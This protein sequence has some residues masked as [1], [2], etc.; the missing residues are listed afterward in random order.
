MRALSVSTA[1]F[2]A[3]WA[4]R[5]EGE[6]T[7]NQILERLL[8]INSATLLSESEP[9]EQPNGADR[10]GIYMDTFDIHFPEGFVIFRIYKGVRYEAVVKNGRWHLKNNSR[11]YPSLHKLSWAVVSGREN[12]W[13]S[14]KY[15]DEEGRERLIDNLRPEEKIARRSTSPFGDDIDL[16]SLGL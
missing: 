14:W 3:I 5:K 15:V 1:V 9:L 11:N 12:S 4:A 8:G 13:N 16:K 2:A 6:E 7:E 10:G